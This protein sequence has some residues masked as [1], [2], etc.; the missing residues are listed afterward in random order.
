LNNAEQALSKI[1]RQGVIKVEAGR[2]GE[3]V[4]MTVSDN[5]P[6]I[7]AHVMPFIFDPFFTTKNLGEGTGLGLSIAHT[8]IENH[9]GTISAKSEPGNTMFTIELPLA[10]SPKMPLDAKETT[11]L[12][13]PPPRKQRR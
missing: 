5:G 3:R 13:P 1:D 10:R 7:P 6:G 12:P 9:G 4:F 8:L 11:P 2:R